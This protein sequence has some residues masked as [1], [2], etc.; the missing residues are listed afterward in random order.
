MTA[1][2]AKKINLLPRGALDEAA[3]CLKAMA[4]PLRLRMVD[5]LMQGEFPVGEIAGMCQLPPHQTS[6]HLRLLKAM[7]LLDCR[8]R[9]RTIFYFIANPRLPRLIE[10]IRKTCKT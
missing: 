3:E 7:G 10:C 8:R 2:T 6:E 5:I 9:G 4:H 1:N